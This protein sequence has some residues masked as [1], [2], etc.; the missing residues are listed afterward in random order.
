LTMHRGWY[1]FKRFQSA[2]TG[3]SWLF[4]SRSALPQMDLCAWHTL[5]PIDLSRHLYRRGECRLCLSNFVFFARNIVCNLL[6]WQ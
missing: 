6:H 1:F 2:G 3:H 5:C 4:A